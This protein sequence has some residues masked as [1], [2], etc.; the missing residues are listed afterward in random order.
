MNIKKKVEDWSPIINDRMVLVNTLH[1]V[2][3]G[4]ICIVIGERFN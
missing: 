3:T 4:G 2:T 1:L